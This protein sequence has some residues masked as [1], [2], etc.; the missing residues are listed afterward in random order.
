[1]FDVDVAV[2][3]RVVVSTRVQLLRT[4]AEQGLTCQSGVC[5]TLP[6]QSQPRSIFAGN[7][8]SIFKYANNQEK[9]YISLLRPLNRS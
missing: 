8:S 3:C 4:A 2:F 9:Y 7:G 6:I 5:P 1:M